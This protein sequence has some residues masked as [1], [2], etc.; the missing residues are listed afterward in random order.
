MVDGDDVGLGVGD[1]TDGVA[2]LGKPEGE[3]EG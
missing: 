1:V 3:V 2:E